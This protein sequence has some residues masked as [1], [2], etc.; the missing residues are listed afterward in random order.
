MDRLGLRGDHLLS[1]AGTALAIYLYLLTRADRD[2]V[3]YAAG[4]IKGAGDAAYAVSMPYL[5]AQRFGRRHLGAIFAANRMCGVVGSGL[6]P[7]VLG[8]YADR[9]SGDFRSSLRG[10][11]AAVLLVAAATQAVQLREERRAE[12]AAGGAPAEGVEVVGGA[13]DVEPTPLLAPPE[14]HGDAPS[15]KR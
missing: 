3:A 2:A 9:T 13:G 1:F 6:G 5:H 11:S 14:A 12:E 8:A 7:L 15:S 10:I 4:A